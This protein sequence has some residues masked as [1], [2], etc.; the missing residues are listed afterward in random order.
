MG[1][2]TIDANGMITKA[3]ERA[4]KLLTAGAGGIVG[5]NAA[6]CC[7]AV[8]GGLVEQVRREKSISL[9]TE[10]AGGRWRVLGRG[11]AGTVI[12][13]FLEAEA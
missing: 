6:A 10:L 9:E 1:V 8:L 13:V 12:L 2:A 11:M 5:Q 7:G 3:N 4:G